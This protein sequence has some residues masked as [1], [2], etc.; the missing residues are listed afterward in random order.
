MALAPRKP[1]RYPSCGVLG[2]TPYCEKHTIKKEV[3]VVAERIK[4]DKERGTSASRGYTYRWSQYSKLYRQS[5]PLCVMC[6]AEG[7][8]TKAQCVDHIT[9]VSGPDDPEFYNP[10]NHQSLCNVHH[11]IKSEAEGNRFNE[12]QRERFI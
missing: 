12:K 6:E 8:L 2:N 3:E 5:N 4:Y 7:R 9:P 1:C 10:K 11:N